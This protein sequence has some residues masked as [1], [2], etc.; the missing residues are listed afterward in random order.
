MK[1]MCKLLELIVYSVRACFKIKACRG[2][3]FGW[4][5]F[6]FLNWRRN[7]YELAMNGLAMNFAIMLTLVLRLWP[8]GSMNRKLLDRALEPRS[9]LRWAL[10]NCMFE[11]P[12]FIH[13]S[14][15]VVR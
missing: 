1:K 6:R 3:Q 9:L 4:Q 5:S 14:S 10:L 15:V 2:L 13:V 11:S 7:W 12:F 8:L